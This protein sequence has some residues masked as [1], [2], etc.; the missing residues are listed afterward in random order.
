MWVLEQA[1]AGRAPL[2]GKRTLLWGRTG[3]EQRF[4]AWAP[5]GFTLWSDIYMGLL[6]LQLPGALAGALA[7]RAWP[8][9]W[10]LSIPPHGPPQHRPVKT[11]PDPTES[12]VSEPCLWPWQPRTPERGQR[13]RLHLWCQGE[14]ASRWEGGSV[15]CPRARGPARRLAQCLAPEHYPSRVWAC[16]HGGAWSRAKRRPS[17]PGPAHPARSSLEVRAGRPGGEAGSRLPCRWPKVS[18]AGSS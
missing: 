17:P 6:G 8:V 4:L 5:L 12:M 11:E 16:G 7:S 10:D 9:E 2:L 13:R 3:S 18:S 15:S 1:G 14:G